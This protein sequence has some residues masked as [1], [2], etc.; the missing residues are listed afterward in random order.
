MTMNQTTIFRLSRSSLGLLCVGYFRGIN[1]IPFPFIISTIPFY[2]RM[3][4]SPSTNQTH[5]KRARKNQQTSPNPPPPPQN[6]PTLITQEIL[7][8]QI[9]QTRKRQQPR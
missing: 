8:H 4:S 7:A 9:H 1:Q 5:P 2:I 6:R 3:T